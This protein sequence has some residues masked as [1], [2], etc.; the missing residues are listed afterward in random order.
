MKKTIILGA[1]GQL[2]NCIARVAE[3]RKLN[4]IMFPAE[5]E[6]DIL[7]P[8]A[9]RVL[10]EKENP[11]YVVN[12]AAYTAVDRAEEDVDK[13][14]MI[15][16]TGAA[17]IADICRDLKITM[18]HVSTDFVFQGN[19]TKL[20]NELD[21]TTPINIYGITKLEGEQVIQEIL[22][23]HF[24]IRTAW[25]YS[26]FGNNFVKTMQRLGRERDELGVIVDQVGTPTYGVDLAGIIL[27]FI[28]SESKAFGIYHYSNEGAVSW[29]DFAQ[30]IFEL[31]NI[32][33][34]VKAVRTDEYVTKAVRPSW[35]VMDKTKI[36]KVLGTPVPYWRDSLKRCIEA[37]Q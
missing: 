18:I 9:L 16:K 15:N 32:Q 11:A 10:F 13:A 4:N 24:I 19:Q 31:S 25:L 22:P 37:I 17:N 29:Y 27:D 23:E 7:S 8:D 34:T 33:V 26:E 5:S 20:L 12:C 30:A 14:R 1:S 21:P 6:S 3:E 28:S 35:S 36:R 2:G